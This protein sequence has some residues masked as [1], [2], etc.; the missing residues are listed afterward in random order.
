MQTNTFGPPEPTHRLKGLRPDHLPLSAAVWDAANSYGKDSQAVVQALYEAVK[1]L[2][3]EILGTCVGERE[4][5]EP[6][7]SAFRR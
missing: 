7:G 3:S 6:A 2:E 5:L 1:A 4:T